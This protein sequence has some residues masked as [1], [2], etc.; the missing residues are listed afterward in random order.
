MIIQIR[1]NTFEKNRLKYSVLPKKE[2]KMK[3]SHLYKWYAL[4]LAFAVAAGTLPA[5]VFASEGKVA[6]AEDI[7]EEPAEDFEEESADAEDASL[8][9]DSSQ[10]EMSEEKS[11]EEDG[12][13]VSEDTAWPE[14]DAEESPEEG[15]S[16]DTAENDK[17]VRKA[18][19]GT[20]LDAD[21]AEND[22]TVNEVSDQEHETGSFKE[23]EEEPVL[24]AEGGDSGE[25]TEAAEEEISKESSEN[26]DVGQTKP[27]QQSEIVYGSVENPQ[28]FSAYQGEAVSN[29]DL[30][31]DYVDKEMGLTGELKASDGK[32]EMS[33]PRRNSNYAVNILNENS[34]AAY[35]VLLEQIR[36]VAAGRRSST[37]FT[38][39]FN[40]IG[41]RTSWT[42]SDL[43]LPFLLDA[44]GKISSEAMYA[45]IE[46]IGIDLGDVWN[47]LLNDCPYDL[48]WHDISEGL[49]FTN[50]SYLY[51]YAIKTGSLWTLYLDADSLELV[52]CVAAE[53]S[54]SGKT[55]TF[56]TKTG[57][58]ET[59]QTAR[60]NA[61]DI[62]TAAE[63]G[64][65]SDF[66]KLDFYR[67]KIRELSDYNHDA[68]DSNKKVNYGNPWQL[69][70]VFDG[71]P[72]TKVVCEGYSKA[73]KYLCDLTDFSDLVHECII[74]SGKMLGVGHMWNNVILQD[75]SVYLVDITNCGKDEY[76][77]NAGC[78]LFLVGTTAQGQ[79]ADALLALGDY[80]N[81]YKFDLRTVQGFGVVID[82]VYEDSMLNEYKAADLELSKGRVRPGT[83]VQ[84]K[85]EDNS[86]ARHSHVYIGD[87]AVQ[88]S[89]TQTGLTGGIHCAICGYELVG[90]E[91]IAKLPHTAGTWKITV[92]P[93]LT[94]T[95]K[96]TSVCKVCG[97]KM[98]AVAARLININK[99][100]VTGIKTKV[101]TGKSITQTPVVKIGTK[102]LKKGTHYTVTYTANKNVGTASL[103][104]K[105]KGLYGGQ[106]RKTFQII[107]KPTSISRLSSGKGAVTVKWKKQA[108]QTTGYEIQLSSSKDLMIHKTVY[109]GKTGTTSRKITGLYRKKKY[110][111]R[112]RTFKKVG[113]KRYCSAWSAVKTINTK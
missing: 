68:A 95:G 47:A 11:G 60:K 44:N 33:K 69:I 110:Y 109:I 89:C 59:V 62:V 19:E 76:D 66:Q 36:D 81:G 28:K 55:G 57:I 43:D 32:C 13:A 4:L 79:A 67:T 102:T 80:R 103:Y 8:P 94:K 52:A 30:F 1:D 15:V 100:K 58:G 85:Y 48:Y 98:T 46:D 2:E 12:S 91:K 26:S 31:A 16:E 21:A 73:F 27:D 93:T 77:D 107:P 37:E 7:V 101:Y 112:I 38:I 3:R 65:M 17:D 74:V 82:Y 24:D 20:A 40:K 29:D 71:D 75:G 35:G 99:A 83:V 78:P 6:A 104:I 49:A 54:E 70:W 41:V 84:S 92:A 72:A 113:T 87:P 88:V 61:E 56:K 105:G 53:Y 39:P 64:G 106:I 23:N 9:D 108:K 45:A 86:A 111:V 50:Y 34:R 90:Q 51:F 10:S 5:P 97:A 14:E 42:A 96:K 25:V 22:D 18:A 63:K